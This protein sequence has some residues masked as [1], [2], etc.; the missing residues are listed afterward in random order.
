MRNLFTLSL[1]LIATMIL[2]AN[3]KLYAADSMQVKAYYI[4]VHQAERGILD[5][6]YSLALINY[7]KAFSFKTP[8]GRDL[9]NAFF[10]A[11]IESDTA[12]AKR[13]YDD[14]ILHGQKRKQFEYYGFIRSRKNDSLYKWLS[15]D[16]D[17]LST[18]ADKSGRLRLANII[19]GIYNADQRCRPVRRHTTNKEQ[20]IIIRQ[21]SVDCLEMLAFIEKYGFPS[22]DKVGM[23]DSC[24]LGKVEMMGTFDLLAW[25]MR[26]ATLALNNVA[27]QAL[28]DG[29]LSP[30]DYAIFIDAQDTTK[31]FMIILPKDTSGNA[32][33]Y[34]LPADV[35]PYN[36]RR[37]SIYL[38]DLA[39]Y[40][41]KLIYSNRP[42]QWFCLV[43]MWV[44]A[45]NSI[46][47]M[48]D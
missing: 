45:L 12:S 9:Y 10:V 7:K 36:E 24:K 39:T 15:R 30:D 1:F 8:N 17:S 37:R 19:N 13:W 34:P 44:L 33:K 27:L 43:P 46:P 5:S 14:I 42:G 2:T 28:R 16:Y 38:D 40:R 11:Y 41:E 3:S 18:I 21:D 23:F 47:V 4:N 22:Y 29:D 31:P 25:H 32:G 6:N 20:E 48:F 26:H 35:G